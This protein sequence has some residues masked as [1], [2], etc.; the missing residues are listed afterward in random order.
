[1]STQAPPL[2][3]RI[4]RLKEL[5][6]LAEAAHTMVQSALTYHQDPNMTPNAAEFMVVNAEKKLDQ[7]A[8]HSEYAANLERL[9]LKSSDSHEQR[10][11]AH[12]TLHR[13]AQAAHTQQLSVLDQLT[14]LAQRLPSAEQAALLDLIR[15]SQAAQDELSQALNSAMS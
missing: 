4:N 14:H 9:V 15:T 2:D 3:A 5:K 8:V 11:A 10:R 6:P 7:L 12:T 13:A 1:M